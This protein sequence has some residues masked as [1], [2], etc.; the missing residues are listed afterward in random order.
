M[1]FGIKNRTLDNVQKLGNCV[2]I[3]S[4][5]TL[6]LYVHRMWCAKWYISL[7]FCSINMCWIPIHF[8]RFSHCCLMLCFGAEFAFQAL[9]HSC[10]IEDHHCLVRKQVMMTMTTE[11]MCTHIQK[12]YISVWQ[13]PGLTHLR[14]KIS[15]FGHKHKYYVLSSVWY[16]R[17]M[18]SSVVSDCV[19][20]VF[21]GGN[22][23]CNVS[24][25][26]WYK[27][28][29][30]SILK[31][32]VC[33]IPYSGTS[34]IFTTAGLYIKK[35]FFTQRQYYKSKQIIIHAVYLFKFFFSY[36]NVSCLCR[37][38]MIIKCW[39]TDDQK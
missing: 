5:Q 36:C 18:F 17:N 31:W 8:K 32:T 24:Y 29:F 2:N 23:K 22:W 7:P 1:L 25:P 39:N 4:L 10:P 38:K 21:C 27:H 30:H 11:C 19:G 12:V 20:T 28:S 14:Y 13:V 3:L 26:L 33:K 9:Q 34:Y 6:R 35:Q 16:Y 15:M 37:G